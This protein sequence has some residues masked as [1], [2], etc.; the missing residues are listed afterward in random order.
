MVLRLDAPPKNVAQSSPPPWTLKTKNRLE[1]QLFCDYGL[2]RV[3][4]IAD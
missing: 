3:P 1:M 2:S 4:L